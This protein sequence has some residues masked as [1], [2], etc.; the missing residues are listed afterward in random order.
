MLAIAQ[1]K[2]SNE[3]VKFIKVDINEEWT[4]TE[5]TF[6]LVVCSLVL[7]HIKNVDRIFKL[8]PK[9]LTQ[10]GSSL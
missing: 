10:N 5:E 4:F 6:D 8:I 3:N 7:E 9:H 2:I 1:R